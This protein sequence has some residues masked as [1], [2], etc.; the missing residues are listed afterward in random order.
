MFKFN[1]AVRWSNG[2]VEGFVGIGFTKEAAETNAASKIADKLK[3][4]QITKPDE[5]NPHRLKSFTGM[6]KEEK[7]SV[8]NDW[9]M[10]D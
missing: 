1:T 5:L 2:E 9:K 7:E 10:T 3:S 4:I 8:Q 6:T